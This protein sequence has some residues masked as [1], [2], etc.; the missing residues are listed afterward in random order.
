MLGAWI[1]LLLA[2]SLLGLAAT[3]IRLRKQRLHGKRTRR[4]TDRT[5]ARVDRRGPTDDPPV[6]SH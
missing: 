2:I 6:D 1:A 3:L 4:L 5:P